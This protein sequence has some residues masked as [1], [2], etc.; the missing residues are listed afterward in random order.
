MFCV[1]IQVS[2]PPPGS[3][4]SARWAAFG[5]AD[6]AGWARRFCQDRRRTSG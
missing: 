1:T 3:L 4:A 2:I 6:H 5:S